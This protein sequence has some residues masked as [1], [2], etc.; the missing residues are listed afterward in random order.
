M[1]LDL[2]DIQ[3]LLARGYSSLRLGLPD[4][5]MAGFSAEFAEGMANR[6]RFLGDLEESDPRSWAWGG[7]EGPPVDGLT[8]LYAS[9][10]DVL[11]GRQAELMR[12]FAEAGI[13]DVT[14]LDNLEL[15]GHEPFGFR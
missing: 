4:R 6:S 2:D 14:E 13:R 7:P 5:V 11:R 9:E 8:M 3:G 1:Q 10:P 15:T 12:R